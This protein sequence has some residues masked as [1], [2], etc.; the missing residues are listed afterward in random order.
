[1]SDNSSQNDEKIIFKKVDSAV[2]NCSTKRQARELE[3]VLA[4]VAEQ[5]FDITKEVSKKG[6]TFLIEAVVRNKPLAARLL[7]AHVRDA[8]F[9]QEKSL[10]DWT[11]MPSKH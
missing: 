4:Q 11:N 8:S 10:K 2:K 9:P 3:E 6:H 7:I 5:Q 1:M